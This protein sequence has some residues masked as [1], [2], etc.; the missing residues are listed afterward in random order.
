MK[1]DPRE[2]QLTRSLKRDH[3]FDA[4]EVAAQDLSLANIKLATILRQSSLLCEQIEAEFRIE[5]KSK[6]PH[7]L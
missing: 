7:L 6:N 5:R 3:E 2:I 1:F 4:L